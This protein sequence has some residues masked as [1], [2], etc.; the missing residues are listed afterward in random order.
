MQSCEAVAKLYKEDPSKVIDPQDEYRRYMEEDKV[1]E[2]AAKEEKYA[3]MRA[4]RKQETVKH[5]V[6]LAELDRQLEEEAELRDPENPFD[7]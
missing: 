6:A 2:R 1:E 4:K 5:K 7:A 3:A